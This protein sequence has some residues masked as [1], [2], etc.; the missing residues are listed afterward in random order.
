[1]TRNVELQIGPKSIYS[2][3]YYPDILSLVFNSE[4]YATTFNESG[5]WREHK[6][7][8]TC[9][10]AIDNLGTHNITLRTLRRL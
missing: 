10:G 3:D 9:S 8:T 5:G 7:I 1:M 4:D 2:K 6:F